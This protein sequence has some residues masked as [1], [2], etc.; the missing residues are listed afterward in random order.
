MIGAFHQ[1]VAVI[2]DTSVLNTLDDRELRAGL[3]EVIKY[4][5][6]RDAGFFDW[7]ENN[8][9]RMLQREPDAL[10]HAIEVSCQNK[11]EV[12]AEDEK[13]S[14]IR[15][16]LNLGHTFGHAIETAQEYK[17]WL[18]GEA[19]AMGMLLAADLSAGL[20]W[21]DRNDLERIRA[22][23]DKAGLPV[24]LPENVSA[25]LLLEH[26]MV[27]KKNRDGNLTL[28]LLQKIGQAVI[29]RD[30]QRDLIVATINEY[31]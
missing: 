31:L 24:R 22:L 16:I 6:I 17:G 14:G 23:I 10:S 5:L 15:A 11:A 4:G 29:S 28:I 12:V 13:E 30:I 7:L 2:A 9:T 8:M 26:M 1:P 3:A 19:V 18:H 21:L 25:G 20:G 27:D